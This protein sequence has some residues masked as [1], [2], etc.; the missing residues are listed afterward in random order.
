[1][2][3]LI[4]LGILT[5]LAVLPLGIHVR[6]NEDGVLAAV[7]L[8]PVRILLYPRPKKPAGAENKKKSSEKKKEVPKANYEKVSAKPK[9]AKDDQ[10][11]PAEEKKGGSVTDFLPLV[12]VALGLL[13]SLRRKLR[14]NVLELKVI[15][16]G[17]DPCDLAVNYGKAWAALGNLLPRL[18]RVLTIQKRDLEIECDF[19]ASSTLITARVDLTITLGRLLALAAVYGFRAVKEYIKI[20]KKRKGGASS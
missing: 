10:K 17:D 12:D 15:M 13:N 14:V 2:G 5:L 16:A 11:K 7:L 6:Y 1:M 19:T 9:T 18:E 3:W 20:M 8:G 4:T